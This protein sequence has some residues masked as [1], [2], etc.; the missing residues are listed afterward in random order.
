MRTAAGLLY[1]TSWENPER[2]VAIQV[3]WNKEIKNP[4]LLGYE[5]ALRKWG[6]AKVNEAFKEY[7]AD[8]EKIKALK[9]QLSEQ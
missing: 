3:E 8:Q 1:A 2:L 5:Q 7:L 6:A 4:D 9:K